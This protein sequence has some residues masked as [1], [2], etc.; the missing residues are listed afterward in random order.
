[1]MERW[2]VVNVSDDNFPHLFLSKNGKYFTADIFKSRTFITDRLAKCTALK[3]EKKTA[4]DLRYE[5]VPAE[6]AIELFQQNEGIGKKR[7]N[8]FRHEDKKHRRTN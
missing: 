4:N 5:A 1:M 6:W 8:L 3:F 2:Y 7:Q